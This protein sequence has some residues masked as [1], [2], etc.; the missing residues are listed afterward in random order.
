[1]LEKGLFFCFEKHVA[2]NL[3]FVLRSIGKSLVLLWGLHPTNSL[4][5]TLL[6]S[7]NLPV[8]VYLSMIYHTIKTTS[9]QNKTLKTN[10]GLC[11]QQ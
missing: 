7:D 8:L 1:M 5:T 4:K 10:F 11:N 9:I 2:I 6:K 3:R